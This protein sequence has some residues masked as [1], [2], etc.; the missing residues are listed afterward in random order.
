MRASVL[1]LVAILSTRALA[2]DLAGFTLS[3]PL[4]MMN[5]ADLTRGGAGFCSETT[6]EG[7]TKLGDY[8]ARVLVS[9]NAEGRIQ[10]IIVTLPRSQSDVLLQAAIDKFGKPN[11]TSTSTVQNL[12]GARFGSISH[13]W[14]F[15]DGAVFMNDRCVKVDQAC[16]GAVARDYK[17]AH[18]GKEMRL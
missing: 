18:S 15:P 8:P 3:E 9:A 5:R 12:F 4:T 11:A 1:L 14:M 16:I 10:A 7:P 2:L 13:G 17:A 6:C